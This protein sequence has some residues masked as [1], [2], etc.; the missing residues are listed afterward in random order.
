MTL[1]WA[2]LIFY[3]STGTFSSTFSDWLI[4]EILKTLHI[5]ISGRHF[6]LLHGAVRKLAHMTEYAFFSFFLYGCFQNGRPLLWRVRTAVFSILIAGGYAMSDEFHQLF[7]PGRTAS[8]LDCGVDTT[9]A[10]FGTLLVYV[11]SRLFPSK[12][13]SVV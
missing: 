9:G 6:W 10:M 11:N 1:V 3:L 13:K 7:V 8:L 2:G 5:H 12:D 4:R